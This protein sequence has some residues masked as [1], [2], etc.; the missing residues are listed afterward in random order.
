MAFS[1]LSSPYKWVAA[2]L[3]ITSIS[4]FSSLAIYMIWKFNA[5][6]AHLYA[7]LCV[8]IYYKIYEALLHG[9]KGWSLIRILFALLL[10]FCIINSCFI[11]S[12]YILPTHS[13]NATSLL[14]VTCSLMVFVNMLDEPV[15]TSLWRQS[16]FWLNASVFFYHTTSFVVWTV[17]NY[18][19]ANQIMSEIPQYLVPVM[20]CF[21][22]AALA[23]SLYLNKRENEIR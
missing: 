18:F 14:V 11:Q 22:Y 7:A 23:V 3:W 1:K 9:R 15:S 19:Q 10:V 2:L 20:C 12:I 16:K 13:V 4:E 8:V 6:I 17:P 5:P 21:F